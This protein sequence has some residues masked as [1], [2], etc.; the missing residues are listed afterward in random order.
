MNNEYSLQLPP[1]QI[2]PS[3]TPHTPRDFAAM[4]QHQ[5][6][7]LPFGINATM[8]PP[9]DAQ[10]IMQ[11]V[12][13]VTTLQRMLMDPNTSSVIVTGNPGAGKSTLAALL[14]QRL[15]QARN[16]GQ[17]A[18]SRLVWLEI[19]PY[20]TV[21]DMLAAILNGIDA[22][23]PGLFLLKPEQQMQCLLDALRDPRKNALVV[24][25]QFEAL[26]YPDDIQPGVAARGALPL[27]LALLQQDLGASRLLLTSYSSPFDE[28]AEN[29]RVRS[30]LISRISIPEGIALLQQRGVRGSPEELSLV[31]QRCSGHVFALA[32]FGALLNLSG[33]SLSY[34]LNSDDYQPMWAGDVTSHLCAAVYH[35]LNPIQAQLMHALCLYHE[36]VPL[37]GILTTITGE[38]AF[39]GQTMTV[40]EH[41]LNMLVQYSLVQRTYNLE[42]SAEHM[43]L[44]ILHPLLRHYGVEHY[45]DTPEQR[46]AG[47]TSATGLRLAPNF[48]DTPQQNDSLQA[49]LSQAHMQ[50]AAYYLHLAHET[51]PPQEQRQIL[52]D[53]EPFIAAARHYCLAWR[54]QRAC[55]LIFAEHLHEMMVQLGAWNTLIG[56][57]TTLLPPLGVIARQDQGLVAS[58]NGMLYGRLGDYQQ[59]INFFSQ[60]L[61][62]QKQ[63]GDQ[64][65]TIATLVNQGEMLRLHGDLEQSYASFE[66]AHVLNEQVQDQ[67]LQCAIY[68]NLGLLYHS[69]RDFE[70]ACNYYV[71]ALKL[72]D[73]SSSLNKGMILTNLGM[74]LYQQK[75]VREGIAILLAALSLRQRI[76]DPAVVS[77]EKFLHAI[78]AKLG[79]EHYQH[80]CQEALELQ[81]EVF[82]RFVLL[83]I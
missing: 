38:K 2:A 74:L 57:Y 48:D 73:E 15:L 3:A 69:A 54:W 64:Q 49:A 41:E 72:T 39:G 26:L 70:L 63:M 71:D 82:S 65:G 50:A 60:A 1:G 77:L 12:D 24:L 11:R 43:P 78:E 9:T 68:H 17:P 79:P 5:P 36:S 30:C 59:S 34:F 56:L 53:V 58:Y 29:T 81:Q 80:L 23:D 6:S 14:F 55:D 45:L 52:G 51:A 32:L 10:H 37:S 66:Q 19:S 61:E 27:F 42:R 25:D 18:P 75:Q 67:Q 21:P 35:F 16:A 33:I 13:E 76:H 22:G 28:Y 47:S 4:R 40:F 46:T 20:T 8:P 62:I 31:W 44:F 83:N 7:Q